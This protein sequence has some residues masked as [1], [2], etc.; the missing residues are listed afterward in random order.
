MT[1]SW[2]IF[3]KSI[4]LYSDNIL[5][6]RLGTLIKDINSDD[7]DLANLHDYLF[8]IRLVKNELRKRDVPLIVLCVD[9]DYDEYTESDNYHPY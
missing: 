2:N 9:N 3:D 8:S 5:L 7:F 4:H 6:Y 1:K